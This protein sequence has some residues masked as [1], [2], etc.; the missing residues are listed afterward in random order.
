MK[1]RQIC[2]GILC[3]AS[4][5]AWS[6]PKLTIAD[7]Q[8]PLPDATLTRK[9]LA[10]KLDPSVPL[11]LT[12]E[13]N[14][15][16]EAVFRDIFAKR[17]YKMVDA[18]GPG[19]ESLKVSGLLEVGMIKMRSRIFG[20]DDFVA[21]PDALKDS[22]DPSKTYAKGATAAASNAAINVAMLA[23]G[24]T[25]LASAVCGFGGALGDATGIS[26][27]F[28]SMLTGDPRGICIWPCGDWNKYFQTIAIMVEEVGPDGT[29]TTSGIKV[30]TKNET[31]YPVQLFQAALG[32]LS[33]DLMGDPMPAVFASATTAP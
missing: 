29:N 14:P 19:V 9:G 12:V 24:A 5:A 21:S 33:A 6:A 27:K 16:A 23:A 17:G 20:L 31:L 22:M 32:T 10:T 28:N 26:G 13:K 30:F 1:L 4:T 8:A 11:Y 3:L 7:P 25:N 18:P 2:I 15:K